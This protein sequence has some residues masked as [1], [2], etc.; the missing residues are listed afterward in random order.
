MKRFSEEKEA[1]GKNWVSFDAKKPWENFFS[2]HRLPESLRWRKNYNIKELNLLPDPAAPG[3][4]P[5]IPDI[6]KIVDVT[7]IN[8]LGSLEESGQWL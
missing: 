6:K 8:H 1:N 4:I 2:L 5:S 3:S 7:E